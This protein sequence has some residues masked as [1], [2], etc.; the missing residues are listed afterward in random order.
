M[1]KIIVMG[2][3]GDPLEILL[4]RERLTIGRAPHNDVVLNHLAVSLEHA[5]IVA[6]SKEAY[7]EDLGSTNGSRVNGQPIKKHYLQGKDV[8]QIAQFVLVYSEAEA[9]IGGG[10]ATRY[11]TIRVPGSATAAGPKVVKNAPPVAKIKILNGGHAGN[12]ILLNKPFMTIGRPGIQVAAI[13]WQLDGY[14]ITHIEGDSPPLLN[15]KSIGESICPL[16]YDDV[17]DL[18]GT[19]MQFCAGDA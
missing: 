14:Y 4:D 3:S 7:L 15:A 19:E 2:E 6:T 1:A 16:T 17:I 12:A 8:I 5:V 13:V 10:T 11:T 18:G 9:G